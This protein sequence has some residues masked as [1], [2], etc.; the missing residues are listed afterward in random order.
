MDLNDQSWRPFAPERTKALGVFPNQLWH[1]AIER[2]GALVIFKPKAYEEY[3]MS[4]AGLEYVCK[5]HQAGRI[6]GH[7]ALACRGQ[8][9]KIIVVAAK[10]VTAVAAMVEGV[11]P[12][13][14]KFGPY[15]WVRPNFTLDSSAGLSPDETPF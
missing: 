6:V 7:V 14:G 10:D 2:L 13:G 5:A 8:D 3:P 1:N 9:W 12:R 15:W 4:Q 11:P